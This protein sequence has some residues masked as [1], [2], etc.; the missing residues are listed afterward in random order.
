MPGSQQLQRSLL[1]AAVPVIEL[2]FSLGSNP[3]RI[4]RLCSKH[5]WS[6]VSVVSPSV[7]FVRLAYRSLG[8]GR[9]GS[10]SAISSGTLTVERGFVLGMLMR[11]RRLIVSVFL[12]PLTFAPSEATPPSSRFQA[13]VVPLLSICK[14]IKIRLKIF[15]TF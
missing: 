2:A 14:R 12:A 11:R 10:L 15:L 6:E 4:I 8:F 7:D 5:F 9:F 1:S 13:Q 3:G